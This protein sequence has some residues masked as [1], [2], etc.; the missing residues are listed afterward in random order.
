MWQI[1][2]QISVV[3]H[4]ADLFPTSKRADLGCWELC[5]IQW[6]RDSV[7]VSCYLFNRITMM[8]EWTQVAHQFLRASTHKWHPSLLLTLPYL[9]LFMWSFSTFHELGIVAFLCFQGEWYL[10]L[11]NCLHEVGNCLHEVWDRERQ[12][13]NSQHDIWN[14]GGFGPT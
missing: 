9:D 3:Q 7:F 1:N 2:P 6:F 4:K 11:L 5:S 12:E 8:W 10:T 13:L 14:T